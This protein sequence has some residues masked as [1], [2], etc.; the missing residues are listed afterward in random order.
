MWVFNLKKTN[1]NKNNNNEFIRLVIDATQDIFVFLAAANS[2]SE[3]LWPIYLKFAMGGYMI[4]SAVTSV[5]TVLF[6]RIMEREFD[7][8][9]LFHPFSL[10]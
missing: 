1:S 2:K 3:R 8:K 4:S 10:V 7:V 5:A 9:E 6:Q